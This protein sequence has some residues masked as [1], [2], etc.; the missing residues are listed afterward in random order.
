MKSVGWVG[1][2]EAGAPQWQWET[3]RSLCKTIYGVCAS[4]QSGGAPQVTLD[5]RT[6]GQQT[7]RPRPT[8]PSRQG[9]ARTEAAFLDGSHRDMKMWHEQLVRM[10]TAYRAERALEGTYMPSNKGT[11][12]ILWQRS[13]AARAAAIRALIKGTSDVDVAY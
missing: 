9:G 12:H 4:N 10:R 7:S 5:A 2:R 13:I 1:G 8:S 11:L 6:I 3:A